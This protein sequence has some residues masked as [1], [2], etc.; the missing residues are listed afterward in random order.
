MRTGRKFV[1]FAY[2]LQVTQRF[3]CLLFVYKTDRYSHV[4]QHVIPNGRFREHIETCLFDDAAKL[5]FCHPH[6]SV[7]AGFDGLNL[8]RYCQAH[9]D[10]IFLI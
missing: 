4:Y 10:V 8:S 1:Q 5:H 6:Q 9:N 2:L 3:L 7:V